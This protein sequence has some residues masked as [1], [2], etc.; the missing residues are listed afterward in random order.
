MA[1]TGKNG[2]EAAANDSGFEPQEGDETLVVAL[3]RGLSWVKAAEQTGFS[4]STIARRMRNPAF[5]LWVAKVRGEMFAQAVG[6]LARSA[7]KAAR[8][9][10]G[11]L[12]NGDA[13]L[14]LQAACKILELGPKLREHSELAQEL[15]ELR[16]LVAT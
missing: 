2:S 13:K 9:L 5:R 16:Q 6:I 11:L 4:E 12:D 1:E 3:A 15:A 8:K 10:T 7:V 14:V